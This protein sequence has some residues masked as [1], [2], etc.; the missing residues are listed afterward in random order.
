MRFFVFSKVQYNTHHVDSGGKQICGF[1]HLL[2]LL[3]LSLQLGSADFVLGEQDCG[4][5]LGVLL[6]TWRKSR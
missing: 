6:E 2:L 3:Y 5:N 1:D 4:R